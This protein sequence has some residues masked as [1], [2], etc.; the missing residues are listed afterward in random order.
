ML[1]TD[2]HKKYSRKTENDYTVGHALKYSGITE[3]D[4]NEGGN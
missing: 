2:P 1:P 3:N 4:Y